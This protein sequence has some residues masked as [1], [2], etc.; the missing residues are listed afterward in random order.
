MTRRPRPL[1]LGLELI[2]EDRDVLVVNKPAGLLSMA[3]EKERERTAYFF[4]MDYVRKGNPKS[5]NR[6]FIVHRLDRETSGVLL[7]A[8]SE[9]AKLKLQENWDAADKRYLAVVRG[10]PPK[11]LG[12]ITSYLAEN[13]T[14]IVYSTDDKT[15]GKLSTTEYRLLKKT[16]ALA[17]V[18]VRLLTGRKNQIRVHFADNGFPIAGDRKYGDKKDGVKRLAL[19]AY[20]IE[21][22]HPHTGKPVLC[23]APPPPL[24]EQLVGKIEK[25]GER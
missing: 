6:V 23:T 5:H 4:M 1:P 16:T 13:V 25:L 15:R 17:L 8:K 18:E 21:F 19:H 12:T 10:A 3:T 22:P 20:Q 24:F 7:L 11:T 2:Y 14:H 9:E